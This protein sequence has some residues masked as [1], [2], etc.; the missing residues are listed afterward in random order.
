[1][2]TYQ[3]LPKHLAIIP[4]GNRRWAKKRN[5]SPW[6]GHAIGAKVFEVIA[7]EVFQRGIQYLSLW[8]ISDGNLLDRGQQEMAK[9]NKI[10]AEG[11]DRI[12]QSFW[13]KKYKVRIRVPGE[14]RKALDLRNFEREINLLKGVEGRTRIHNQNFLNVFTIY[15]GI[16]EYREGVKKIV[17]ISRKHPGVEISD[18]LIQK[19]IPYVPAMP[20]IDLIIR[21]GIRPNSLPRTSEGFMAAYHTQDTEWW[22]TNVLWPDFDERDYLGQALDDF[23][24]SKLAAMEERS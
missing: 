13:V 9:L 15:S 2:K 20:P 18:Q 7:Q 23:F 12:S 1:M 21:T 17:E 3:M 11:L 22:F 19:V 8:S 16:V 5:W 4:D 24:R 10:V 14:W 6:E